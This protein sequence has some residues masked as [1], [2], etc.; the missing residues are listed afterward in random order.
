SSQTRRFAP[1][2]LDMFWDHCL[3]NEWR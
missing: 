2:A 1:I 3:A